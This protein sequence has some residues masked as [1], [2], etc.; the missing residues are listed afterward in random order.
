MGLQPLFKTSVFHPAHPHRPISTTTN[1][2]SAPKNRPKNH[3]EI[4]DRRE[5][6]DSF[7]KASDKCNHPPCPKRG[8]PTSHAVPPRPT[9]WREE[10]SRNSQI[11]TPSS[12]PRPPA[13]SGRDTTQHRGWSRCWHAGYM[14]T[15]AEPQPGLHVYIQRDSV[16][17]RDS[18][19][20]R[21]YECVAVEGRG[22]DC[23]LSDT[24]NGTRIDL[25]CTR[26]QS[27]TWETGH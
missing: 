13:S 23:Q 22:G 14:G 26:C 16:R 25:P 12:S 17:G 18:V 19:C 11:E 21:L 24:C 7:Q 2:P 6:M 5:S 8:S 1:L 27:S 10:R 15:A 9:H 4:P 3:S 20:G